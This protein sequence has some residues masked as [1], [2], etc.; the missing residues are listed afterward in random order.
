MKAVILTDNRTIIDSYYLGEPAFSLYLE[1]DGKKILFDTGYSDVF[2]RNAQKM[3]IDLSLLDAVVLSHGHN[4]HTGGLRYLL[5]DAD[6]MTLIA[7][8]DVFEKKEDL[9]LPVGSP[10]SLAEVMDLFR[11]AVL[12]KGPYR[13]SRHLFYLGEVPRIHEFENVP[14]GRRMAKDTW[15]DDFCL[16]DSALVYENEEGIFVFTGCSHSGLCNILDYAKKVTGKAHIL[17]ILGGFHLLN[18]DE[19][20]KKTAEYLKKEDIETLY[21]C[22]CVGLEALFEMMKEGLPVRE[23]GVGMTIEIM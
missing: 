8:P 19:R 4:D 22:H 16:D 23:C 17:G 5:Y 2:R 15:E 20:M 1:C 7:H 3:G 12:T 13:I 11:E 18:N 9:G 14:V 21:P 6:N 10:L